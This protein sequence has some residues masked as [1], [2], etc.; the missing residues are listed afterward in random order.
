MVIKRGNRNLLY[1]FCLAYSC[2]LHAG[3]EQE[4]EMKALNGKRDDIRISSK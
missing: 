4:V 3:R 1:S 2:F